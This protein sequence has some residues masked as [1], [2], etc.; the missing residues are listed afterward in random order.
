LPTREYAIVK[1]FRDAGHDIPKNLVIRLSAMYPDVA[2]KIP[3][4]LQ[5]FDGIGT[6]EVHQFKPAISQECIAPTQNGE[7][8]ECRECWKRGGSI[9]YHMH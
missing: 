2:V 1:Q 4:S 8:R 7:C 6:S 5:N 3:A 9:S